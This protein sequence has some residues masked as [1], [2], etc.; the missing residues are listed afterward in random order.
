MKNYACPLQENVL[1]N[2]KVKTMFPLQKVIHG[3][4]KR[5]S[6]KFQNV[7]TCT[8]RYKKSAIPYMAKL[9]NDEYQEKISILKDY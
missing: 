7:K 2:E 8:N 3:M 6:R 5:K 1:K 9:L 4:K